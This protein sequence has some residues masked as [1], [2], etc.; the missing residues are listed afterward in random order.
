MT[1]VCLNTTVPI[2]YAHE[3]DR[4]IVQNLG[5][6]A[7]R[8]DGMRALLSMALGLP[9]LRDAYRY[10][11]S[12]VEQDERA[13][14]LLEKK[15]ELGTWSAVAAD[16]GVSVERLKQIVIRYEN[17]MRRDAKANDHSF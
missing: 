11:F 5:D 15:R 8:A 6:R 10:R 12:S 9:P 7:S 2:E 14:R 13:D 17:R 4:W 1:S 16:E 3:L